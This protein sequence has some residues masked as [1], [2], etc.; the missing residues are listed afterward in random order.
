MD[1]D[2]RQQTQ[3]LESLDDE[4]LT[5]L[6]I[7]MTKKSEDLSPDEFWSKDPNFAHVDRELTP[8][9]KEVAADYYEAEEEFRIN[10]MK[11]NATRLSRRQMISTLV[12]FINITE[13]K[14]WMAEN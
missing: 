9:E 5:K 10:W 1:E 13:I 2:H 7:D 3:L 6:V 11:T 4:K 8:G 12:F 14:A